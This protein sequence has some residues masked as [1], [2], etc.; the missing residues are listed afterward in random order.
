MSE[1]DDLVNAH[2][3]ELID[4]LLRGGDLLQQRRAMRWAAALFR[5]NYEAHGKWIVITIWQQ[6]MFTETLYLMSTPTTPTCA[7]PIVNT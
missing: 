2:A 6:H 5:L 3:L 7:A 1:K 4:V